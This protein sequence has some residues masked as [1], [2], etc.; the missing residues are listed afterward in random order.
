MENIENTNVNIDY[1]KYARDFLIEW[2]GGIRSMDY[3]FFEENGVYHAF[4]LEK[5]FELA[6]REHDL[7][8][9]H[10]VSTDF[11]NWKY[12]GT[13]LDGYTDGWDNL[14]LATG[15]VAKLDDT[16]YMMY[17][18]HST[19]QPGLGIAKSKDLYT[20]E[21]VGDKPQIP[22]LVFCTAEYKGKKYKCRILADPYIYPEKIDGY[23]YCYVNSWAIDRPYNSRGCQLM[24]KSQNLVDWEPYKIA[25]MTDGLDRL[26]TAQVWEHNGKWYMSFGGCFIDPS[27]GGFGNIW[28]DNFVYMAESFDGPYEKQSWSR[29]VYKDA[30]KR[31]YTQKQIKDPFGEDV[32]LPSAPY[33]GVLWPYKINYADDGSMS[34]QANCLQ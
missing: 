9:G 4:F 6:E 12:E 26:E 20:W 33:D 16:Y 3:W 27:K 34:L 11:L 30:P 15:S 14:H 13:I 10:S 5:R 22:E 28:N 32:M 24:F 7:R 2:P 31:P 29:L 18:G 17:T 8:I 23:F 25:V 1:R 19:D 21:R